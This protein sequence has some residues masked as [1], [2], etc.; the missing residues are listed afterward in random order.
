MPLDVLVAGVLMS[1]IIMF[2]LTAGADFGGGFWNL[3][4]LGERAERQRELIGE[5]IGPIWEANELWLIAAIVIMWTAFPSA[6]AAYGIALFIPFVLALAGIV[7]RGAF[8]AFRHEAR[9]MILVRAYKLFGRVFGSASIITPVYFGIAAGA[10]AS[11][12]IQLENGRP[13]NGYIQPWFKPFPIVIGVLA[14]A[15]R[16]YLAAIYLTL[17]PGADEELQEQFRLRALVAS[18]VVAILGPIALLLSSTGAPYISL[19]LT[20]GSGLALM[21]IALVSL[22]SSA[23]LLYFR[24]YWLARA[25]AILQVVAAF[26]AWAIAQYPYLLV[27]DITIGSAAAPVPTLMT[28]LLVVVLSA[29]ALAPFLIYL[30]RLFKGSRQS[31]GGG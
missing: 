5:A 1:S 23:V 26:C 12:K 9:E 27:P 13:I 15:I 7:L 17:E 25:V 21:I 20:Q 6:F 14:L 28:E 30:L 11:G 2:A 8:F 22:I 4:S 19:R 16:A 18:G 10:I 3:V 31:R 24:R 29:V